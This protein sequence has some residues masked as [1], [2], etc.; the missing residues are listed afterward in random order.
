MKLMTKFAGYMLLVIAVMMS[1]CEEKNTSLIK[2]IPADAEVALVADAQALIENAGCSVQNGQVTLSPELQALLDKIPDNNERETVYQLLNSGIDLSDVAIYVPSLK[3]DAAV[4]ILK[5]ADVIALKSLIEKNQ[6]TSNGTYQSFE[7]YSCANIDLL[8]DGKLCFV[9]DN[10]TFSCAQVVNIDAKN[11]LESVDWKAQMLSKPNDVNVLVSLPQ[12][13]WAQIGLSS[14]PGIVYSYGLK[15]EQQRLTTSC[16]FCL[17]DGSKPAFENYVGEIDSEFVKY[18][19]PTDIFAGAIAINPDMD[20]NEYSKEINKLAAGNRELTIAMAT[21]LPYLKML[22]GTIAFAG[23]PTAGTESYEDPSLGNW[24]FFTMVQ[25]KNESDISTIILQLQ[26][27]ATMSGMPISTTDNGFILSIPSQGV[28]NVTQKDDYLI[29]S[30]REMNK[31]NSGIMSADWFSGAFSAL[32]LKLERSNPLMV[33]SDLPFGVDANLKN[34]EAEINL[35]GTDKQFIEAIISYAISKAQFDAADEF[36]EEEYILSDSVAMCDSV[37]SSDCENVY[38]MEESE[39][40]P[41]YQDS[42]DSSCNQV[43]TA[44]EQM[45]QFPGGEAELMKY[46]SNN[47]KY[48]TMAMENNIQGRV[49]VQFVVTK[50]GKIGEVKVVRSKDPD[51]DKEAVRIVKSLPNFIPGKM[52]GQAVSVWYTLP[53]TF[54]LQGL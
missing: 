53:I 41:A 8:V 15:F 9:F 5:V 29:I 7:W 13:Y 37:Q 50:T 42:D 49:V 22:G 40:S 16:D 32:G 46:I 48:P 34:L 24:S 39:E 25:M 21:A 35:V 26:S 17:A 36:V 11:S 18:M 6:F 10:H 38:D 1:S 33:A 12:T 19:I 52:N 27:F 20:W 2:Y 23:G 45:P 30:N 3:R 47:I 31:T 51:L 28:I 4:A 14:F 43:Y 44:V 54:K